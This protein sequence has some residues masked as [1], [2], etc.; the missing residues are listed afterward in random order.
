MKKTE[1]SQKQ[2]LI[3]GS[4]TMC[5]DDCR[6]HEKWIH[7]YNIFNQVA[8]D[9]AIRKGKSA[10]LINFKPIDHCGTRTIYQ[11]FEDGIF[12]SLPLHIYND[13]GLYLWNNLFNPLTNNTPIHLF[14]SQT[15][16]GLGI[17]LPQDK[18]ENGFSYRQVDPIKRIYELSRKKEKMNQVFN[19]DLFGKDIFGYSL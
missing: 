15:D 8:F 6:V 9:S 17:V 1:N 4:G 3:I 13:L 11:Y 5:E 2:V 7:K 12:K 14:L 19:N 18:R 16:P 10:N